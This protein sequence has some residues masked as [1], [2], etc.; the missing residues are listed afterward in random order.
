MPAIHLLLLLILLL[1]IL[2]LTLLTIKPKTGLLVY[3]KFACKADILSILNMYYM[4][5]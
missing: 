3:E 5:T 2:V 4:C 1:L